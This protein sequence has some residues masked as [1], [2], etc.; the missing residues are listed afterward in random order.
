MM[1]DRRDLRGDGTPEQRF[2]ARLLNEIPV[3]R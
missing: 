1:K 3:P 2:I